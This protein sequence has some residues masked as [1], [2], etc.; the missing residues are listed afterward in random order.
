MSFKNLED[1]IRALED[2]SD[3][4]RLRARIRELEEEQL[5]KDQ[6]HAREKEELQE[7]NARLVA[8]YRSLDARHKA[9]ANLR[10][11]FQKNSISLREIDSIARKRM[12]KE[13][14]KRIEKQAKELFEEQLPS[15]IEVEI[16]GYPALCSDVTR[17]IV[18]KKAA[19]LSDECLRNS[20][21]WPNWFK[22]KVSTEAD[23]QAKEKM[24]QEFWGNVR[25][26]ADQEII[27]RLPGAWNS[28]LRGYATSFM[29]NTLQAQLLS[30]TA[31]IE[32]ACPKCGGPVHVTLTPNDIS[33]MLRKG[34][35]S[36]IC[37][38]SK[39]IFKHNFRVTLGELFWFIMNGDLIPIR[40][41][42]TRT[43]EYRPV[44]D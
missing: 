7:E 37:P 9:L 2:I 35:V 30:L 31:P 33:L 16:K 29:K 38:F 32:Y 24:D 39:G 22:V 4:P 43:I 34:W 25:H 3:A 13:V 17:G 15:L 18:W 20:S 27:H 12:D 40:A 42:R 19:Q 28:F 6:A 21:M 14:D 23:K 1:S 10:I 41:S 36:Y 8:S 44:E 5:K 11:V 26:R